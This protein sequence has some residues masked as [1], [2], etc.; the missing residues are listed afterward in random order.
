[1]IYGGSPDPKLGQS[2]GMHGQ[3]ETRLEILLAA[4]LLPSVTISGTSISSTILP[5]GEEISHDALF[6][7]DGSKALTGNMNA[8]GK[9][10]ESV[11][12]VG[13]EYVYS[14]SNPAYGMRPKGLSVL[15]NLNVDTLKI[16]GNLVE[17]AACSA[18]SIGTSTPE[19]F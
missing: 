18:K 8:N 14:P 12:E 6:S 16:A 3:R 19:N 11:N 4:A 15:K 17:G 13:A 1:M 2:R 9:N 7:L 10:I 5:P